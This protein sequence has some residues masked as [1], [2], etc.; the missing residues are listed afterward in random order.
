MFHREDCVFRVMNIWSHLTRTTCSTWFVA[1]CH[2][3]LNFFQQWL[4]FITTL[5]ET[6]DLWRASL[7]DSQ[8]RAVDLCCSSRDTPGLLAASLINAVL[9]PC[10]VSVHLHVLVGVCHLQNNLC[11]NV[12]L[13]MSLSSQPPPP[14]PRQQGSSRQAMSFSG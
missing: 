8:T 13:H 1:N 6:L 11:R 9:A 2:K 4:A 14:L 7:T 10:S 12:F 3:D 5:P